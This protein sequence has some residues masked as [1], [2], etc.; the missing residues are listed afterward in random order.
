MTSCSYISLCRGK[1][2][3]ADVKGRCGFE[4]GCGFVLVATEAEHLYIA[5]ILYMVMVQHWIAT[6]TQWFLLLRLPD[7]NRAFLDMYQ[8]FFKLILTQVT[9][10]S[11]DVGLIFIFLILF[12]TNC[13]HLKPHVSW[14]CRWK[15]SA[16]F[17]P[18]LY[19]TDLWRKRGAVMTSLICT[20]CGGGSVKIFEHSDRFDGVSYI[21]KADYRMRTSVMSMQRNCRVPCQRYLFGNRLMQKKHLLARW[22]LVGLDMLGCWWVISSNQAFIFLRIGFGVLGIKLFWNGM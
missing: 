18:F 2:A 16:W 9:G 10:F 4:E 22:W 20:A 15:N 21:V 1:G 8:C 3:R 11:L 19:T 12:R 13:R 7:W 17:V 6:S 5:A 14:V